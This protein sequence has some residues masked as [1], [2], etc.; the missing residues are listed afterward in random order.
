[1]PNPYLHWGWVWSA[2]T[3][4]MQCETC[5]DNYKVNMG[6]PGRDLYLGGAFISRL[7]YIGTFLNYHMIRHNHSWWIQI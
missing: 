7:D 1:M 2:D 4:F 5:S 6:A 3:F